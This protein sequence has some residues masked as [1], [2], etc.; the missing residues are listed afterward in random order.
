MRDLFVRFRRG[1]AFLV[2]LAGTLVLYEVAHWFGFD[3]GR[4]FIN[5]CLSV[6]ASFAT[7][8]LLDQSMSSTEADRV[9]WDRIERELLGV[10]EDVEDIQEEIKDA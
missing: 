4:A 1:N 2:T 6:E 8:M 10:A 7:C 3:P 9:R 5:Y